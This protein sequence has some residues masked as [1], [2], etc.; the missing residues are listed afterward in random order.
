MK[1]LAHRAVGVRVAHVHFD[2]LRHAN[3]VEILREWVMLVIKH[4]VALVFLVALAAP[5]AEVA[6]RHEL[7]LPIE[8][9][10]RDLDK[11]AKEKRHIDEKQH[12]NH[13]TLAAYL[14]LCSFL[15]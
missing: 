6:R 1:T 2:Q 14:R 13:K 8:L 3:A 12:E 7:R 15:R 5:A 9:A 10:H 4:R 11:A